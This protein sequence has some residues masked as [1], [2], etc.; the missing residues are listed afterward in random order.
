M[1]GDGPLTLVLV[2]GLISQVEL[3][4]EEPAFE[5]FMGRLAAFTRVVTPAMI[6]EAALKAGSYDLREVLD[7]VTVPALVLHRVGDGVASVEQARYLAAHVAG[8]SC[9]ELAGDEHLFFLGDQA[10][11][12]CATALP[13]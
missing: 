10:P 13:H 2:P 3:A 9:V 6:R 11:C 7:R 8:A 4:W 1:F 5:Q 12:G